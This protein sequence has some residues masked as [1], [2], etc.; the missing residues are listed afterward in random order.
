MTSSYFN[1]FNARPQQIK[2][3]PHESLRLIV[4]IPCFNEPECDSAVQSL[5]ENDFPEELFEII[6]VV[7]HSETASREIVDQNLT[8]IRTL[9][10]RFSNKS[11]CHIIEA[12]DLPKKHAG[13]GW[14]RKIGMD[15]ACRRFIDIE[16]N[17]TIICYDADSQCSTNYLKAIDAHFSNPMINGASIHFEHPLEGPLRSSN[18]EAINRYELFL[19]YY[20]CGL[21]SAHLPFA[22]HTVGSSMAVRSSAY[23]K[24]GGMNRRKAGEDFYFLQKII[25][26][27]NFIEISDCHVIPSAR[28]SNRVPFGTGKAIGK[29][30]DQEDDLSLTYDLTVFNSLGSLHSNAQELYQGDYSTIDSALLEFIINKGLDKSFNALKANTQ[31]FK[32]FNNRL[33]QIFDAFVSLKYVHWYRDHVSENKPLLDQSIKYLNSVG[34]TPPDRNYRVA[35]DAYRKLECEAPYRDSLAI[36]KSSPFK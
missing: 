31:D 5:Y 3:P 36:K 27:G 30:L 35:L 19:R 32:S 21:K 2:K 29:F 12:F 9:K 6:V 22:F 24:Q 18:Y 13:V 23:M 8:S 7:N 1:R 10:T 20:N 34:I 33:Y 17:G 15:E 11:N 16:T 4:V 14:A 25:Q 28:S 26:L